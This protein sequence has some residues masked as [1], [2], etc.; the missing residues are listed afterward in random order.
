MPIFFNL[1]NTDLL[2]DVSRFYLMYVGPALSSLLNVDTRTKQ[3][4][5]NLIITKILLSAVY[6]EFQVT[7]THVFGKC[8]SIKKNSKIDNAHIVYKTCRAPI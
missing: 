4:N 7:V 1:S 5:Y 6:T 8:R 3:A 2:Q